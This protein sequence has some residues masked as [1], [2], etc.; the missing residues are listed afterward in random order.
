MASENNDTSFDME[1]W[2]DMAKLFS[3]LVEDEP[4]S[5]LPAPFPPQST[6]TS[7]DLAI[8][9]PKTNMLKAVIPYLEVQQQ[10][11]V[12]I[13]IKSLELKKI[14]DLYPASQLTS[15]DS[16]FPRV[17][18]GKIG[19]LQS[20]RPHCPKDKQQILDMM[21]NFFTMKEVMGKAQL[22]QDTMAPVGENPPPS[23]P[24]SGANLDSLLK[25]LEMFS[26]MSPQTKDPK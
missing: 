24:F 4:V 14:F 11:Y 17:A 19:I 21:L 12:A 15:L 3:D 22:F 23:S 18:E 1:Q 16:P 6:I 2:M 13:F 25:M 9:S 8:S 20:I 7:F 5:E 26:T 10:R